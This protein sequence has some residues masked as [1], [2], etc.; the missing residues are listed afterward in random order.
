MTTSSSAPPAT[1]SPAGAGPRPDR[2]W[3]DPLALAAALTRVLTDKPFARGLAQAGRRK[4]EQDF[5]LRKSAARLRQLF[6]EASGRTRASSKM[7]AFKDEPTRPNAA[8]A[9]ATSS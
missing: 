6:A 2:R 9:A 4:A 3:L 8:M 5:D 1:P 7:L